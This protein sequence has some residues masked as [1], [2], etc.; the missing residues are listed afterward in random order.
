M[1]YPRR[2]L[3][4]LHNRA[5][6]GVLLS[7]WKSVSL[8]LSQCPCACA[9][10]CNARLKISVSVFVSVWVCVSLGV[11]KSRN[12]H[13]S[14][15]RCEWGRKCVL[16]C[17]F[18][19]GCACA[20]A[21]VCV[22][23]YV[24]ECGC[25]SGRVN[26]WERER[27]KERACV[28]ICAWHWERNVWMYLYGCIYAHIQIFMYLYNANNYFQLCINVHLHMCMYSCVYAYVCVCIQ[29]WNIRVSYL[30]EHIYMLYVFN[31]MS[32]ANMREHA[33]WEHII[34]T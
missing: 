1:L 11:F 19:C 21:C 31:I 24:S 5:Q 7:V 13:S 15:I 34:S 17:V 4:L 16:A 26:V 14:P 33:E 27:K 9:C 22:S 25:V 20:C 28:S 3:S 29:V 32:L 12:V 8:F 2:K 10:L 30:G 18:V 6:R 23:M